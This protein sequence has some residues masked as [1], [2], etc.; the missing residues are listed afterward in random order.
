MTDEMKIVLKL[1]DAELHKVLGETIFSQSISQSISAASNIGNEFYGFKVNLS[2]AE[3]DTK[4]KNEFK[5]F[6]TVKVDAS[7]ENGEKSDALILVKDTIISMTGNIKRSIV[8]VAEKGAV[9][10]CKAYLNIIAKPANEGYILHSYREVGGA[11]LLDADGRKFLPQHSK[12]GD[13][14][15]SFTINYDADTTLVIKATGNY[16]ELVVGGNEPASIPAVVKFGDSQKNQFIQLES[17][18]GYLSPS[19]NLIDITCV[20]AQNIANL[21]AK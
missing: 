18:V 19:K 5:G 7:S 16:N 1:S 11:D 8:I 13:E 9:V 20:P 10:D 17:K 4:I 6:K 2:Q 12:K 3:I 21:F 15:K 14:G